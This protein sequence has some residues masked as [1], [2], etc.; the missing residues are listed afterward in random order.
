MIQVNVDSMSFQEIKDVLKFL[1]IKIKVRKI[2]K[3][4]EILKKVI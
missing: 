1:S 3:L 4:R 2:D